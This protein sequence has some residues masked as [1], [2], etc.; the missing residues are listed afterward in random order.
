[1]DREAT[2]N[3]FKL[4]ISPDGRENSITINQDIDFYVGRLDGTQ[5]VQ[6]K[7]GDGRI[8]WVQ[9]ARGAVDLNDKTLRAGDGAAIREED[10]LFFDN[11]ADVEIL[12]FDMAYIKFN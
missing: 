4:V 9:I 1:M 6:F 10:T 5:P 2:R 7:T 8:Q 11:A 3:T 12:L